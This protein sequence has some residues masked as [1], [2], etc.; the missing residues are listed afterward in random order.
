MG[1]DGEIIYYACPSHH[2][3]HPCVRD[4]HSVYYFAPR[5]KRRQMVSDI[6]I[7][8]LASRDS[9]FQTVIYIFDFLLRS[10]LIGGQLS[11]DILCD[12]TSVKYLLGNVRLPICIA[13][14][15]R[16]RLISKS[17]LVL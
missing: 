14:Q 2:V 16:G 12:T 1:L 17:H 5:I 15:V 9:Y 4:T 10:Q 3:T 7:Y 11:Q 8:K 6:Y 13:Y